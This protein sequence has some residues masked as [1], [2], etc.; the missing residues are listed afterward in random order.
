MKTNQKHFVIRKDPTSPIQ[1]LRYLGIF[2]DKWDYGLDLGNKQ[3][4]HCNNTIR[5]NGL[6][7]NKNIFL[8]YGFVI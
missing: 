1:A 8:L 4:I 3:I 6:I 5:M 7:F 2:I